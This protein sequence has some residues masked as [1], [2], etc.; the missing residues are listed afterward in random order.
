[1]KPFSYHVT[2]AVLLYSW[3]ACLN[4]LYVV[5]PAATSLGSYPLVLD[6]VLAWI[7][8]VLV[9]W[10][11]LDALPLAGAITI[12]PPGSPPRHTQLPPYDCVTQQHGRLL[13]ADA[14]TY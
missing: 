1:M 2:P 8:L 12:L 4:R 13:L 6:L 9:S 11:N 7:A 5:L 10:N 14:L 3:I